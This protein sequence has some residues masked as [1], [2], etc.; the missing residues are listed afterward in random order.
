[1]HELVGYVHDKYKDLHEDLNFEGISSEGFQV[2]QFFKV[3]AEKL[4]LK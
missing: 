1:M 3:Y 4:V 2:E